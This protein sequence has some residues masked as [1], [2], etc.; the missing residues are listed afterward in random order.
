[1][2]NMNWFL[3]SGIIGLVFAALL[4]FIFAVKFSGSRC[5]AFIFFIYPL[6]IILLI[7]GLHQILK[8]QKS[9]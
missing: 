7:M 2:K 6:S 8:E 5:Q 9:E 4:Q 1:M 3:A